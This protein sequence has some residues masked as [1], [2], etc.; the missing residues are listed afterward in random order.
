MSLWINFIYSIILSLFFSFGVIV[1]F[2]FPLLSVCLR[3]Y[4]FVCL[5]AL[6]AHPGSVSPRRQSLEH[7]GTAKK[8]RLKF[9]PQTEEYLVTA[10]IHIPKAE[11]FKLLPTKHCST[12]MF[13]DF[14]WL[15][16]Q[17]IRQGKCAL[18][19]FSSWQT[20]FQVTS[21]CLFVFQRLH[22]L[23]PPD[24]HPFG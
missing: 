9:C 4:F 20:N 1:L 10:E 15:T 18:V 21:F 24:W 2:S 7:E 16:W 23:I 19:F 12:H 14:P 6:M 8:W 11:T 13:H 5:S 17:S 22:F 3:F